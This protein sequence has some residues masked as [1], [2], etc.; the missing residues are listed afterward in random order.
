MINSIEKCFHHRFSDKQSF[1]SNGLISILTKCGDENYI[2][3]YPYSILWKITTACN[4]RCKHCLYYSIPNAFKSDDNF[5][6]EELMELAKF[7]VEELNIV[8]FS[9]SGG[10]PFLQKS[11]FDLLEYLRSKNVYI[12][13][14]TNATLINR[15][16]A[17]KLSEILNLNQTVIQVSL[18]GAEKQINEKIRGKGSY[19]KTI[20]GIQYLTELGFR[21]RVSCTITSENIKGICQLYSLCKELKVQELLLGKFKIC[22]EEQSYLD[23]TL[24][25]VFKYIAD[26]IDLKGDDES[27]VVNIGNVTVC[28]FLNYEAGTK[29][30]DKYIKTKSDKVVENL[31]C[32]KHNR[33][34]LNA[35]GN[36][37]L[38]TDT[39][40]EEFCLGNLKEKSFY[41]I[42]DNRF[43]NMFFQKRDKCVCKKCKY[44]SVCHG[45]CPAR[46][47]KTYGSINA[48]DGE[49]SYGKK[50]MKL[51][52]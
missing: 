46:S 19:E 17:N 29:L 18:E 49:C 14:K 7:F 27:I 45:G 22:S 12:D 5:Q 16:V 31:A 21:V 52:C 48:P 32:H 20:K 28:D 25:D 1:E 23:P 9:I 37:Y 35:D 10:E 50:I 38:C 42:W 13:I 44:V 15:D 40:T 34:V 41:E 26:L 8:S 51:K 4:L 43:N 30:L 47:Y 6:S 36:I 11:I 33:F 39:E 2:H 3:K 24:D